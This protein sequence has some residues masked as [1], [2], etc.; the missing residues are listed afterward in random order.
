M[1]TSSHA[2]RGVRLLFLS[3]SWLQLCNMPITPHYRFEAVWFIGNREL[4]ELSRQR[5]TRMTNKSFP[6][7]PLF[8]VSPTRIILVIRRFGIIP[9]SSGFELQRAGRRRTATACKKEHKS[10]SRLSLHWI[11]AYNSYCEAAECMDACMPPYLIECRATTEHSIQS[12][13]ITIY[14]V[15]L[16]SRI[17]RAA[18]RKALDHGIF[19]IWNR[20]DMVCTL[21]V[22][23]ILTRIS[24]SRCRADRIAANIPIGA[25]CIHR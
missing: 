22:R 25:A 12:K 17:C 24:C 16:N 15:E 14:C 2:V 13:R 5:S 23:C 18:K 3:I 7:R 9:S 6:L 11:C 19:L 10:S 21:F 8:I 1:C 4:K 20:L